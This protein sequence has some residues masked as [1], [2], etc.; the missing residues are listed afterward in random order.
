MPRANRYIQPGYVYRLTHRGYNRE[1]LLRCRLDRIEYCARLRA[2]I[3]KH[4]IVL[5]DF[6]V[7]CNYVHLLGMCDHLRDLSR[8]MHCLLSITLCA[9]VNNGMCN[10][11][12]HL[13][14]LSATLTKVS[15]AWFVIGGIKK[16]DLKLIKYASEVWEIGKKPSFKHR[17]PGDAVWDR[18]VSS[19]CVMTP[20]TKHLS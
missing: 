2:A 17:P 3:H 16:F 19:E 6:C 20:P 5:F 15:A 4:R 10:C 14:G 8:F 12:Q 13:L 9:I 1:F 18:A 11:E 7:T